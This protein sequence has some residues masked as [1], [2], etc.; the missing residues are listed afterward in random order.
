MRQLAILAR[1]NDVIDPPDQRDQLGAV[2]E[3]LHLP[4][5]I[6]ILRHR[7]VARGIGIVGLSAGMVALLTG[8]EALSAGTAVPPTTRPAA[9]LNATSKYISPTDVLH[10]RTIQPGFHPRAKIRIILIGV[11]KSNFRSKC[12]KRKQRGGTTRDHTEL[13]RSVYK[14]RVA[15]SMSWE[16][17]S[18]WSSSLSLF[19]DFGHVKDIDCLVRFGVNHHHLNIAAGLR[20]GRRQFVKQT[21]TIFADKVDQRCR[22]RGLLIEPHHR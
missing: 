16:C 20:H 12:S 3:F 11:A 2:L 14:S 15:I 4:R 19:P 9:T 21:R 13:L 8:I 18:S 6:D 10:R 5:E 1:G 17:R 22:I 7:G